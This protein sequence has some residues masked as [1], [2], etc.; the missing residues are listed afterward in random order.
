MFQVGRDFQRS[1]CPAP[2][3]KL[4]HPEQVSEE[5]VLRVWRVCW[6]RTFR[7]CV[8]EKGQVKPCP[9]EAMPCSAHLT[10]QACIPSIHTA[11][12]RPPEPPSS[13]RVARRME[14]PCGRRAQ[15]SQRIFN[16]WYEASTYFDLTS[17]W[18]FYQLNTAR[19]RNGS[20]TC[21]FLCIF[22]LSY[23][24]FLFSEFWVT[25]NQMGLEFS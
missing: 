21:S 20:Y 8:W 19:T 5:Y 15:E 10:A 22:S 11:P 7:V 2:L 23:S 13:P 6:L 16:P 14:V 3:L 17:S 9:G 18:S 24:N 1:S 12:H 4:G 25:W